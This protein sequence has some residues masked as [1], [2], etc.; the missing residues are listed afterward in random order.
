MQVK[1]KAKYI[2][3]SPRKARLVVD[4]VRGLDVNA[5]LAKLSVLN[6]KATSFVEKV[7]NSA[8]ANAEHNNE[9][10]RD[11]LFIKEIRA[12]DGPTFYRWFPRAHGRA[13]P[14]RK[15]TSSIYLTLEEK[16]PTKSKKVEKATDIETVQVSEEDS[17]EKIEKDAKADSSKGIDSKMS[18]DKSGSGQKGKSGLKNMFRRKSGM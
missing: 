7:L 3:I 16:K 18:D 8:I 11:N 10:S 4:V 12:E 14:K 1:A 6:K 13:T 15:R 17:I 5:A 2:R 9:L